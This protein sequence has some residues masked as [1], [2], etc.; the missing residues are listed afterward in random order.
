MYHTIFWDRPRLSSNNFCKNLRGCLKKPILHILIDAVMGTVECCEQWPL[1]L[2]WRHSLL[3]W[4]NDTN[5]VYFPMPYVKEYELTNALH[6]E[7]LWSPH[8]TTHH[9]ANAPGIGHALTQSQDVLDHVSHT[10]ACDIYPV[11]QGNLVEQLTCTFD[12]Q[13]LYKS[14][15]QSCKLIAMNQRWHSSI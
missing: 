3:R 11:T 7:N 15:T 1:H 8:P 2:Q 5:D 9:T 10:C 13:T 14:L 12:M 6:S 4:G